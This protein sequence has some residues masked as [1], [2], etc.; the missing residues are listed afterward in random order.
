MNRKAKLLRKFSKNKAHYKKLKRAYT[1]L[2]WV[3]KTKISVY[4][5]EKVNEN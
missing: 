3:A 4:I 2:S 5:K 1:A